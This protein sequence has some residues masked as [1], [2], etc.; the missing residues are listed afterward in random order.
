MLGTSIQGISY[1]A[2]VQRSSVTTYVDVHLLKKDF[3]PLREEA[4][5][6]PE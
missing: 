2:D 4:L 3:V 1:I 5:Y 6:Q